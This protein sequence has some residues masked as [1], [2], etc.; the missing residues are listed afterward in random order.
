MNELD[1]LKSVVK[2]VE[3]YKLASEFPKL[4]AL[5]QRIRKLEREK[6]NKKRA[7]AASASVHE[8]Q[9]KLQNSSITNHSQT[10][11]DGAVPVTKR[12]T[13]QEKQSNLQKETAFD[14]MQPADPASVTTRDSS[15]LRIPETAVTSAIPSYQQPNPYAAAP[16]GPYGMVGSNPDFDTY[17]S[18]HMGSYALTTSSH[19]NPANFY[20][21]GSQI[22]GE[23]Y[24]MTGLSSGMYEQSEPPM[25][26][27]SNIPAPSSS[28]CPPGSQMPAGYYDGNT[29]YGGY[30][31]APEYHPS[32]YP[33]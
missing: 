29:A 32:Y 11:Q 27:N 33:Q 4:N 15:N 14:R 7:G 3:D 12:N 18:A 6:P 10:E 22:P 2:C 8:K 5:M 16:I 9:A 28:L 25:S 24:G 17:A 19:E 26:F 20:P 13:V 31:W 30:S 23:T 21:S 1:R